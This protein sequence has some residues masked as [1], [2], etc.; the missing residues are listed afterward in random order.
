MPVPFERR[1]EGYQGIRNI[2]SD[3]YIEIAKEL[4]DLSSWVAMLLVYVY[5]I[6]VPRQFSIF[7]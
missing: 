7:G 6:Y 3:L 5:C 4:R 2:G 1:P